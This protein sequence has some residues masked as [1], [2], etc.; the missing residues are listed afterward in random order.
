MNGT[1]RWR[2]PFRVVL[3]SHERM[4]LERKG[5]LEIETSR[6]EPDLQEL[7]GSSSPT[8]AGNK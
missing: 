1:G 7:P 8:A 2:K 3:E 5:Q 6:V 4:R